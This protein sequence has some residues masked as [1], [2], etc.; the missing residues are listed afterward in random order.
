MFDKLIESN[1][2]GAEFKPRRTFFMVSFVVVGIV[3]LSALVFDLY[4]ANIDLGT[5]NFELVE[6]LA[7]VENEVPK[8]DPPRQQPKQANEQQE[9]VLPS[10]K[11]LIAPIDQTQDAPTSIST[12]P[13]PYK[14]IPDGP[15]KVDPLGPEREGSGPTGPVGS[16][17]DKVG[18]SAD[19]E[20][21]AETVKRPEPPPAVKVEPK[22]LP[23]QSKGVVNGFATDLPKPTYPA[24]A[25]AM[26]LSAVVNVQVLIDETGQVVSAK[27]LDGNVL[28]RQ[29]AERAARKAK[30]KPTLLSD[31]PVKVTGVIVY[32]FKKS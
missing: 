15:F 6:M 30:F 12:A 19:I 22:K 8:P 32:K 11:Q 13:N 4:A 31:E 20:P 17:G 7:P 27:A 18:G 25:I 9:N 24:V 1:M 21:V 10:R 23:P 29:E 26:N 14:S 28:F 2:A 16:V 3:F 5:D